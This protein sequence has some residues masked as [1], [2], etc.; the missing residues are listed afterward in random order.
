[1]INFHSFL[2]FVFICLLSFDICFAFY[3]LYFFVIL[4]GWLSVAVSLYLSVCVSRLLPPYFSLFSLSFSFS[5]SL[6]LIRRM[7]FPNLN[8]AVHSR[9]PRRESID[10]PLYF[11]VAFKYGLLASNKINNTLLTR[12]VNVNIGG[13]FRNCGCYNYAGNI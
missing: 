7:T 9:S 12:S 3:I 10:W 13:H 8:R 5:F 11:L 4:P 1:M 2:V 6:F